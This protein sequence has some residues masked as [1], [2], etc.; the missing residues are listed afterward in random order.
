MFSCDA[1]ENVT[2]WDIDLYPE[3]TPNLH[4]VK[5]HGYGDIF[6]VG[7]ND[8]V[9]LILGELYMQSLPDTAWTPEIAQKSSSLAGKMVSVSKTATGVKT[10]T[11]GYG[12]R[13]PYH[14]WMNRATQQI[15]IGDV[16]HATW[17]IC[18]FFCVIFS[19]RTDHFLFLGK[20]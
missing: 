18:F 9:V 14:N 16:G 19:T 5:M 12:L 6:H 20:N 11:C 15:N 7:P 4:Q 8:D 10:K 3:D 17:Y 1:T 13:H 2:T